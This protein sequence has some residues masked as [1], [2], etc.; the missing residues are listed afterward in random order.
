MVR[1]YKSML[2]QDDFWDTYATGTTDRPPLGLRPSSGVPEATL[3]S[4]PADASPAS[5]RYHQRRNVAC[6][7][8]YVDSG[9]FAGVGLITNLSEDGLFMEHV[10][11]LRVDE[12]VTVAFRLPGSPPF[13]L[14]GKV[15]WLGTG[16]AGL[17]LDGLAGGFA[18]FVEAS[19]VE[20]VRHYR[21]WLCKN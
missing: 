21:A 15:K 20:N 11:G 17:K 12:R 5:R 1:P 16:G 6:R 14:K 3:P 2:S 4:S 9:K 10:P 7:A 8:D 18:G 13:K 19:E